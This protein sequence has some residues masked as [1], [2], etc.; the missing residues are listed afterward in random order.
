MN[1]RN[2][3]GGR[4]WGGLTIMRRLII[5]FAQQ[6]QYHTGVA[7]PSFA[8][9]WRIAKPN[10]QSPVRARSKVPTEAFL[11]QWG[12]DP[13]KIKWNIFMLK[14]LANDYIARFALSRPLKFANSHGVM[15]VYAVV[16]LI[17]EQ[18]SIRCSL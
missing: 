3:N 9:F 16:V 17:F 18:K 4:V 7:N 6:V 15:R 8:N 14:P 2:T 13:K 5:I 1:F 11:E 10:Y 12:E